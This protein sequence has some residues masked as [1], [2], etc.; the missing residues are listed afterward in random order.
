MTTT[1]SFVG[2]E[3]ELSEL[4]VALTSLAGGNG[5]LFCIVGEPG[6]GKS[7]LAEEIATEAS[8]RGICVAW[9]RC[10]EGGGA[11][12]FWPWIQIIRECIRH[13]G[14]DKLNTALSDPAR[15]M[16]KFA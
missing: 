3:R 10:W 4:S 1:A 2:R 12:A 7:R 16:L 13:F 6:I 11:P 15:Q 8:G 5:Q 14:L 9:A